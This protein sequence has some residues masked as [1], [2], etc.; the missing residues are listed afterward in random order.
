MFVLTHNNTTQNFNT[1]EEAIGNA[2][3][4]DT[5]DVSSGIYEVSTILTIDK[6]ISIIGRKDHDD[7][8]P[9]INISTSASLNIAGIDVTKSNVTIKGLEIVIVNANNNID[10]GAIRFTAGVSADF[11]NQSAVPV[12][13]NLTIDDCRI[14]YPKNCIYNLAKNITISNCELHST[15]TTTTAIRTIF[16]Y[17]N[18][19]ISEISN[20]I[21]T[22]AGGLALSG[23]FAQHNASNGFKNTHSG[24]INFHNNTSAVTTTQRF[25]HLQA[26]VGTNNPIDSDHLSMDIYDNN[27]NSFNNIW[28][29]KINI[30]I[31]SNIN[32]R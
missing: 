15:V 9:V 7:T 13:E 20:N 27:I 23:I 8:R 28:I 14:V 5:I 10:Q 18:D 11:V 17:H 3:D 2:T 31:Q 16:F 32:I 4:G 21:F 30:I 29:S 12:N 1:I 6:S 22:T 19:G 26:G 25:I 24:T